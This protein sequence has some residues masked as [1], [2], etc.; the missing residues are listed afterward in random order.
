MGGKLSYGKTRGDPGG[1]G[2]QWEKDAG[3]GMDSPLFTEAPGHE[4]QPSSWSQPGDPAL[5]PRP[6]LLTTVEFLNPRYCSYL[7]PWWPHDSRIPLK[8]TKGSVGLRALAQPPGS[9]HPSSGNQVVPTPHPA[10]QS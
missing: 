2:G 9:A 3:P 4:D 1:T 10:A 5:H 7:G 6:G 8:W